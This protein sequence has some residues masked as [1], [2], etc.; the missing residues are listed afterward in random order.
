M[1]KYDFFSCRKALLQ[2]CLQNGLPEPPRDPPAASRGAKIE[3]KSPQDLSGKISFLQ[4]IFPERALGGFF[5]HPGPFS[6]P[7]SFRKDLLS[8]KDLSGKTLGPPRLFPERS[9]CC[10]MQPGALSGKV[11]ASI[12]PPL[13]KAPERPKTMTTAG[14][15]AQE[16]T[17]Q[18]LKE[19]RSSTSGRTG[20]GGRGAAFRFIHKH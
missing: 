11:L 2:K 8:Q 20:V 14:P 17:P 9:F 1:K 10:P 7:A 13:G 5:P 6:S 12:L 19:T 15:N 18:G 16:T 3:P 4:K